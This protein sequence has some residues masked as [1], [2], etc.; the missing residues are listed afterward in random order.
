MMRQQYQ[1][2]FN[3]SNF[4]CITITPQ[5]YIS[6]NH[7]QQRFRVYQRKFLVVQYLCEKK[8]QK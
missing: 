7:S 1:I 5:Q 2:L 8:L 4:N 6:D 3:Q